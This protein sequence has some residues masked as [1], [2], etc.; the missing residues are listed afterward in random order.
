[1]RRHFACSLKKEDVGYCGKLSGV[2]E[3]R[4]LAESMGD[5][6]RVSVRKISFPPP[7][8]LANKQPSLW[9]ASLS[10]PRPLFQTACKMTLRQCVVAG[11]VSSKKQLYN[12]ASILEQN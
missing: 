3:S 11:P 1:M 4:L 9:K 7:A 12:T 2:R 6:G 8:L 10:Y 5:K